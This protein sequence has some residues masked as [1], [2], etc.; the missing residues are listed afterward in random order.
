MQH[1]CVQ[2]LSQGLLVTKITMFGP[3]GVIAVMK[4]FQKRIHV[5]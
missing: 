3:Q 2:N 4:S 1:L 5:W